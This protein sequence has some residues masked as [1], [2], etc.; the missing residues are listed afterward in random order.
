V[1]D[2]VGTG[3]VEVL[4]LEVDLGAAELVGE[5]AA[6]EDGRGAAGVGRVEE[7][8]LV[9]ELL[10]LGDLLVGDGNVVHGLLEV[11]GHELAAVGTEV[12]LGVGH[13]SKLG[14]GHCWWWGRVR[15]GEEEGDNGMGG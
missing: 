5:A 14:G 12:A 1:V 6:V 13:G 7:G 3:V 11:R 10:G 8:E 15:D 4:A 2:L 9:L